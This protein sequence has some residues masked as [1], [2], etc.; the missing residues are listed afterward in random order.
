MVEYSLAI[1]LRAKVD[2]LRLRLGGWADRDLTTMLTISRGP[3]E[4]PD[5]KEERLRVDQAM[6]MA[7][8]TEEETGADT[9]L[10]RGVTKVR[11][12]SKVSEIFLL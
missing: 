11:C 3:S 2:R 7:R 12:P 6:A 10:I 5:V 8:A 9:V 1:G 4:D